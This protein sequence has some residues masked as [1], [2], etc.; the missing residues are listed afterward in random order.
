[1]KI[2]NIRE[3]DWFVDVDSDGNVVDVARINNTFFQKK[4][5]QTAMKLSDLIGTDK[6]V[7][8]VLAAYKQQQDQ[9]SLDLR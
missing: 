3:V 2:V 1:M 5:Q 4:V 9:L 6:P 8:P 7:T